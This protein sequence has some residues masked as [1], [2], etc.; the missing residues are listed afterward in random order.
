MAINYLFWGLLHKGVFAGPFRDLWEVFF[1]TYLEASGDREVL[2]VL[3]PYLTWRALVV[4]SPVWYP[5]YG[6]DIREALLNFAGNVLE[7][8]A[9]DPFDVVPLL[10]NEK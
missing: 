4:A 5:N 7:L 10:R 9:L 2:E 1:R 3:P 6:D 8:S